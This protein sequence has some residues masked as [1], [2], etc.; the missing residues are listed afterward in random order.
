MNHRMY[1]IPMT[2]LL[3]IGVV[4]F[5]SHGRW[6]EVVLFPVMYIFHAILLVITSR[7]KA[8][9]TA[10]LVLMLFADAL[11]VATYLGEQYKPLIWISVPL[12]IAALY[13]DNLLK[14]EEENE[15]SM[16]RPA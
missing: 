8:W 16:A 10:F 12:S 13:I 7:K 2:L 3:T 15:D 6:L 11:W 5:A 1:S 4:F 14:R 9:T